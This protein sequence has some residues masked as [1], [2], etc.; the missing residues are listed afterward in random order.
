[1]TNNEIDYWLKNG[2]NE[3]QNANPEIL[4]EKSFEQVDD[5]YKRKCQ[6]SMFSR[7]L[8]NGESI[9]RSWICFSPSTGKIFCVYCKLF[10]NLSSN[11][12]TD[13]FCDWKNASR[14]LEE[15]EQSSEHIRATREFTRQS[16][17]ID[18]IQINLEKQ[19]LAEKEYWR[20]IL[21]RIISVVKVL[22]E[23]NLA[24]R[25]DNEIIGSPNNG[26]FLILIE[27]IAEYDDF[28]KN[29]LKNHAQCG[30]GHVNYLSSTIYEEIIEIMA[31]KVE[32][33]IIS[34]LN[35]VKYFSF[36][37]DS[38]TDWAHKD[39]LVLTVRYIYNGEPIERYLTMMSNMG[40]KAE[41]MFFAVTEYLRAHN[42]A[43]ENCRGQSHD[44][45][46]V[47]SGIYNGFQKLI[48][49]VS[50][51]AFWIPCFAHSLNLAGT[52]VMSCCL[53][54]KK[55]FDFLE[56]IY[57]FFSS[58][59][60]RFSILRQHMKDALQ[61]IED[62]IL[63]PKRV[64][65]TRWSS[66]AD[67]VKSIIK[68][69]NTYKDV[70]YELSNEHDQA[71]GLYEIMNKLETGIYA[72]L[73][74][75]ILQNINKTSLKL[76]S[77]KTGLNTS[78]ACLKSLQCF[79]EQKRSEFDHYEKAG[80][81]ISGAQQ[82]SQE[83]KRLRRH[84]VRL[85]PLDQPIS[86]EA[87]FS[88]PAQKFRVE[89][90][91]PIFDTLNSSL[92]QRIAAYDT[93]NTYFGFLRQIYDLDTDEIRFHSNKLRELYSNDLEENLANELIQF[94]ELAKEFNIT[95]KSNN[96]SEKAEKK[97]SDIS[98]EAKLYKL[99]M[100]EE[101][102]ETFPNV[103]ITLRIYLTLMTSNCT[104][105]RAFSKLKL[106]FGKLRTS[107]GQNRMNN[108]I[109]MSSEV[110]LLRELSFDDVIETFAERKSRKICS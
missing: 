76:Q 37:I 10:S 2:I 44:N 46:S 67:A 26:N 107:M 3:L 30:T 52:D 68:H 77:P 7:K 75:D 89:Q 101:L 73:W 11:F 29:H 6:M 42:I 88:S 81:E 86:V 98:F 47:M 105:E 106:I 45:A 84:N 64:S 27:L 104:S 28:L 49:D 94:R 79:I 24:F 35:R 60:T 70:L 16:K 18:L 82:Y 39:Q 14:R 102:T 90:Y 36:S 108:L 80:K 40:H 13:G 5:N 12:I 50:P 17:N 61:S 1:M 8:K 34:D 20:N 51:L 48:R 97:K 69:Y 65:T 93:V 100:D 32:N 38:T 72:V 71:R 91:I 95:I 78:I 62:R 57:V 85:N 59:S 58:S 21:M 63:N 56:N 43:L 15:H 23:R 22:I 83:N 41:D 19:R 92:T 74:N 54:A 25:G 96:E 55:F 103:E 31:R 66:R 53:E 109:L 87:T 4:K 33:K 99:I 110:D 9:K